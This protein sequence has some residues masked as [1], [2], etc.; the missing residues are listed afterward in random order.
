M[1]TSILSVLGLAITLHSTSM[2]ETAGSASNNVVG[3]PQKTE[4]SSGF[5]IG[6]Q[7]GA[8][9]LHNIS[10]TAGP[11][12]VDIPFK[13]GS[14]FGVPFGFDFG[15]GIRLGMSVSQYK[16]DFSNFT[17]YYQGS[18]QTIST[19]AS[20]L[21]SATF[22]PVMAEVSYSLPIVG[23]LHWNIGVGVG[24]VHEDINFTAYDFPSTQ[25]NVFGQLGSVGTHPIVNFNGLSA[26][27]WNFGFEAFTGLSY[28]FT[29]NFTLDVNYRYLQ[30]GAKVSISGD[31]SSE[32]AGFSSGSTTLHGQ[33]VQAALVF[34]F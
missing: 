16:A 22:V 27:Q 18:N 30:L 33:S 8:F 14:A 17:G 11:M 31:S 2:A 3:D 12:S 7:G 25:G 15:N 5:Y 23:G 10:P 13:T 4:D 34:K 6:A 21:G 24:A 28:E 32:I 26:R 29:P 9:W 20:S 1:K 19:G